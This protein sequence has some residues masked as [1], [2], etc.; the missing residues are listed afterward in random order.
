MKKLFFLLSIVLAN[1][2]PAQIKVACIGNSITFGHGLKK[3]E[4][5]PVQ[6]QNLLGA[7]WK[8]ENFGVSGR[9]L[10]S[11]GDFPYIKEKAFLNAKEF[12][13]D[14]VIIKLGTN[15]AKPQNW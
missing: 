1:A 14:V 8:V 10:L 4:T 9:T 3:E 15:D 12:A 2:L 5:Y 6:L 13:P 7:E 11:H